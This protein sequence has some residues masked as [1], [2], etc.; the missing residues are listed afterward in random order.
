MQSRISNIPTNYQNT[1]KAVQFFNQLKGSDAHIFH[2]KA[3]TCREMNLEK[4]P[5]S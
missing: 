4:S 5:L 2:H 3:L 1:H